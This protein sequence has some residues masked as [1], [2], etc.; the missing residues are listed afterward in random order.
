MPSF[1][2][3]LV[4]WQECTWAL[5]WLEVG[6]WGLRRAGPQLGA[7][8]GPLS[9]CQLQGKA[10][11]KPLTVSAL[12]SANPEALL[13]IHS[14]LTLCRFSKSLAVMLFLLSAT[15]RSVKS[16]AASILLGAFGS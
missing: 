4:V 10:C 7:A 16:V 14:V 5:L 9:P 13:L 15:L 6:A 3:W 11:G 2:S 1:A 12:S 8:R